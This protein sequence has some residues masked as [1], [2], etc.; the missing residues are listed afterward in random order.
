MVKHDCNENEI[1][2]GRAATDTMD[3]LVGFIEEIDGFTRT[4]TV[5]EKQAESTSRLVGFCLS[6]GNQ[7]T[8]IRIHSYQSSW[9]TGKRTL[10]TPI[11]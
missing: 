7:V 1:Q 6:G 9:L 10:P 8:K 5:L 2:N 11:L 4:A 3:L